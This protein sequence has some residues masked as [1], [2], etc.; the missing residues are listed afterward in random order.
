MSSY[1]RDMVEAHEDYARQI[2]SFMW[3][4]K[5][6]KSK[7]IERTKEELEEFLENLRKDAWDNYDTGAYS[8]GW[9]G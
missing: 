4:G 9:R 3:E 8:L 1:A 7:K 2:Q 5:P 6:H